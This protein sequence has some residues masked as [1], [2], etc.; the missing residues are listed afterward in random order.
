VTVEPLLFLSHRIPYPPNKGDKIRSYHLLRHLAQRYAVHLGTF[1]DDP[2]DRVHVRALETLCASV[3]TVHLNAAAARARSLAG[4][5]TGAALTVP[6]YRA[7]SLQRWVDRTVVGAGI[8]RCV[9]FSSAPAQFVASH[10]GLRTVVDFC[11]V[12]S[13]KWR[14]YAVAQGWP[15]SALYRREAVRLLAYERAIARRAAAALFAT[16]AEAA[17][18]S[19]LAPESAA[20]VHVVEN[21]VDSQYFRPDA[22]R[23]TP[24]AQDEAAIVFTGAM[25]YWP[26]V[27]AVCWFASEVLPRIALQVPAVRFYVVGMNPA[28]TV[29]AL[30]QDPRIVITGRVPDVRPYVQHARLVVAPLRVA[31]GIQNKVLEAMALARPALVSPGAAEG[32][33]GRAGNE[34]EVADGAEEFARRAVAMLEDRR[35][36]AMGQRARERVLAERDWGRNLAALDALLEPRHAVERAPVAVETGQ[37]ARVEHA[38]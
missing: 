37:G 20:R 9:V 4:L 30:G 17:M 34:F 26:N 21:G 5:L 32:L 29:A 25:N 15:S 1:V 31:R 12:D 7:S 23:P 27:D 2:A 38:R 16:A 3:H 28:P 35:Y 11:D 10:P 22:A 36:E 14:Q 19:E 18:F 24:Y 8:G 13:A 6:Y 33:N